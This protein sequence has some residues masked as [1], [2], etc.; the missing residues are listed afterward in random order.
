MQVYSRLDGLQSLMSLSVDT[1]ILVYALNK[2][3]DVH[4]PARGFAPG[5]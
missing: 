5:L 1:N 3:S 2:D 4:E